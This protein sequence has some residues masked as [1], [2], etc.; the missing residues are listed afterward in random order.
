MVVAVEEVPGGLRWGS[1]RGQ[2]RPPLRGGGKRQRCAGKPKPVPSLLASGRDDAARAQDRVQPF[3][4]DHHPAHPTPP[5]QQRSRCSPGPSSGSSRLPIPPR[6]ACAAAASLEAARCRGS[7]GDGLNECGVSRPSCCCCRC[8]CSTV[9]ERW[10]VRPLLPP[11]PLW[12]ILLLA[13]PY[14]FLFDSSCFLI[15][16]GRQQWR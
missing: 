8:C 13:L 7:S 9:R 5:C 2:S 11:S 16:S 1:R 3:F 6:V 15:L 10:R 12:L 4:D 14:I